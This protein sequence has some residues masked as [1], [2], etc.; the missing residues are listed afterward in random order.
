ML[1][2]EDPLPR[3]EEHLSVRYRHRFTRPCERH[4]DMA[5]HVV[6][7][8][9]GM[10]EV[11]IILRDEAVEPLLQVASG[12]GVGIFHN[13][14]RTTRVLTEHRHDPAAYAAHLQ[15]AGDEVGDIISP[16]PF[17]RDRMGILMEDHGS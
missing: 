3:A 13:N 11:R 6:A 17:C 16:L 2:E 7:A 15:L 10:I 5:G 1:P 4:L 8:F 9:C 12:R 14:Q